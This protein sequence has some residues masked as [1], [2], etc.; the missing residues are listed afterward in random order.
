MPAWDVVD[1]LRILQ[2]E[3]LK[4][5]QPETVETQ[6]TVR[7]MQRADQEKLVSSFLGLFRKSLTSKQ[8]RML[9][10]KV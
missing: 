4:K 9:L 3:T 6:V 7:T 1:I 10:D 8:M 2:H 5:R